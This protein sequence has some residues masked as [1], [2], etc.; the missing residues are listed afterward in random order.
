MLHLVRRMAPALFCAAFP[1]LIVACGGRLGSQATS[2]NPATDP[3]GRPAGNVPGD[4]PDAELTTTEYWLE[5]SKDGFAALQKYK[6]RFVRVTGKVNWYGY[7]LKGEGFLILEGADKKFV[8]QEKRPVSKALPGQT[9][10]LRGKPTSVLGV[11]TWTIVNASGPQPLTMT[12]DQLLQDLTKNAADTDKKLQGKVMVITG[13]FTKVDQG[14]F[15]LTRHDKLPAVGCWFY[16]ANNP[17]V[18]RERLNFKVGQK[19]K[20]LGMYE[21]KG[22]LGMCEP[23]E[24]SP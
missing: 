21:Q 4:Q 10:T 8:C 14:Q 12:A 7:G 20:I 9:V 23:V 19:V 11:E 6:D 15:L 18:D 1:L 17:D 13:Q 22:M 16:S 5:F 2:G 24:V 3:T